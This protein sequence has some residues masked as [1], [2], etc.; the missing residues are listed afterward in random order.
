MN[1]RTEEEEIEEAEGRTEVIHRTKRSDGVFGTH[2]HRRMHR[3]WALRYRASQGE[4]DAVY[5]ICHV[6][7]PP[8]SNQA[9][10]HV[11][12]KDERRLFTL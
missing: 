12:Q 11:Y 4:E 1:E 10:C 7:W 6:S 8:A 2:M 5:Q 3:S 9:L